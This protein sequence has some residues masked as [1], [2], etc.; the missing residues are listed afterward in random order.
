MMLGLFTVFAFAQSTCPHA[1]DILADINSNYYYAEVDENTH[2]LMCG[3]CDVEIDAPSSHSITYY[4]VDETSCKPYCSYCGCEPESEAIPHKLTKYDAYSEVYCINYCENCGW[5]DEEHLLE[6]DFAE[7]DVAETR[8]EAAYKLYECKVC[9]YYEKEYIEQDNIVIELITHEGYPWYGDSIVVLENGEPLTLV[10]KYE[11]NEIEKYEIPYNKDSVYN[12][13]WI[14]GEASEYCGLKIYFPYNDEPVFESDYMTDYGRMETLFIEGSADY[15]D[16]Y[17]ELLIVPDRLEYYTKESVDK[18][19]EA[20]KGIDYYVNE[21]NQDKVNAMT[22]A[23]TAAVSGL[24]PTDEPA[25]FGVINLKENVNVN[26]DGERG[27]YIGVDFYEYDGDYAVFNTEGYTD[28]GFYANSGKVNVTVINLFGGYG[29]LGFYGDAD[30]TLTALGTNILFSDNSGYGGIEV[31]NDAKLTITKDSENIIA[32]GDEYCAGIGSYYEDEAVKA[33]DITIDGG[34]VFALSFDDGAGIG[35][36]YKAGFGKITINGGRIYAGCLDDDGAGIGAGDDGIGGDIVINGGDITALSLDD[37]GSG[38]GAADNGHIDSI[39]INGGFIVVGSDDAA[40]IGAGDSPKSFGGKITINGG[41]ILK[42]R[43]D[44]SSSFIGNDEDN[45]TGETEYN[46]VEINGG[47]LLDNGNIVPVSKNKAG[48]AVVP[49]EITVADVLAD[50]EV[51]IE[52]EGGEPVTAVAYGNKLRVFLPENAVI[53][54]TDYLK[55]G[56]EIVDTTKVFKDVKAKRWYVDAINHC[57]SYGFIAGV[58]K[59]AFGVDT[60][61]TRGMF[62]TVLARIAGV[63]TSSAANKVTTKFTDVK[64]GKYYTNAIKWASEN[65]I[66]AGITKTEYKPDNKLE[67]QQLCVMI[68]NFAKYLNVEIGAV[69]EKINFADANKIG[70]YAKT[71]VEV[72]QMA[73]IINGIENGKKIEVKPADSATRAQAAQLLYMFHKNYVLAAQQDEA[74]AL[75]AQQIAD[76][77]LSALA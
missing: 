50:K 49:V 38:I 13:M 51:T 42:H 8:F 68:V 62:I 41:I 12:F 58:E 10:S 60:A 54:N 57:Y 32:L 20:I 69:E 2:V 3:E 31:V 11:N 23:L 53:T 17:N 34:V 9:Q 75:L 6:H 44:S 18:L 1:E 15:T 55:T 28:S 48:K 26:V 56:V 30:V 22:E 16:L 66:V 77:I 37:D 65:N 4:P 35:G 36:G 14:D 76:E 40:G 70:K 7:I 47:N 63:D 27:Y 71:A 19:V 52:V 74:D 5:G 21:E 72:C 39:T 33:G 43:A 45:T 73:D 24:E 67:R 46:F 29:T 25:T 64:S 61:V 59:D